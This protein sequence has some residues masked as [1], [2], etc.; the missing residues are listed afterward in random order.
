MSLPCMALVSS[1]TQ[2]NVNLLLVE[3]NPG[4]AR[5][6]EEGLRDSRFSNT[7]HHVTDGAEA[8]DFLYQRAGHENDPRPDL[9]LLDWNLPRTSG[10]EVLEEVK[11]D[12]SLANVPII[13]LTSSDAEED[14][15]KSYENRANAYIT[16]PVNPDDFF[17]T[18]RSIEKFWIRAARFP[19]HTNT[20]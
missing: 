20:K 17:E 14:I 1:T 15:I 10:E 3:D 5:L 9:V 19:P 8:L 4:D 18:V 13:V 16:K 6:I 2:Q 7:L 11:T 12:P